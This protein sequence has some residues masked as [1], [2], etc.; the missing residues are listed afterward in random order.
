MAENVIVKP[1]EIRTQTV[2]FAGEANPTI[3][4]GKIVQL[5]KSSDTLAPS[6]VR[7]VQN[8]MSEILSPDPRPGLSTKTKAQQD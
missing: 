1:D 7:E 8:K 5:V 4:H 6:V 3:R 2:R